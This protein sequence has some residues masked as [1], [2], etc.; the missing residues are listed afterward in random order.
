MEMCDAQDRR[1]ALRRYSRLLRAGRHAHSGTHPYYFRQ[2]EFTVTTLEEL[3][4]VPLFEGLTEEKLR[5]VLQEGLRSSYPPAR[6]VG[7]KV[8][9][10]ITCL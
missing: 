5:E 6:S 8:S 3:R 2:G 10:S 4:Q 9:P 7:E 1:E